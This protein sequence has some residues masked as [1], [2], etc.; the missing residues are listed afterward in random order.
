V[1]DGGVFITGFAGEEATPRR[2]RVAVGGVTVVGAAAG[3]KGGAR[4]GGRGGAAGARA[5]EAGVAFLRGRGYG[6]GFAAGREEAAFLGG[7][8]LVDGL[9]FA[10]GEER[11]C[12]GFYLNDECVFLYVDKEL[13]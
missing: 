4:G 1:R 8:L 3:G 12:G 10:A 2:A 9:W 5:K 11:H 7:R 13:D 6:F